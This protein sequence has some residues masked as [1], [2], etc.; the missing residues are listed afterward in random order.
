MAVTTKEEAAPGIWWVDA[1]DATIYPTIH[2]TAAPK[3]RTIQ[4]AMSMVPLPR[5]SAL[6]LRP[7]G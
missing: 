4:P 1:R 2:S 5:D 3:Q 6:Q 7:L